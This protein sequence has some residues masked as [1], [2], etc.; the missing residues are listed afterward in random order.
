MYT[1]NRLHFA[2]ECG[3]IS[4]AAHR[5]EMATKYGADEVLQC[6]VDEAA[7][8]IRASTAKRGW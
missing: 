3:S 5:A 7:E 6:P 4:G 1:I 8:L 2:A